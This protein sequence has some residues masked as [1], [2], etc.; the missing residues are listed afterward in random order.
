MT[1]KIW[2]AGWDVVRAAASRGATLRGT[3]E[4]IGL[5]RTALRPFMRRGV[6]HHPEFDNRNCRDDQP[7]RQVDL[8]SHGIAVEAEDPRACRQPQAD[9]EI[10][11]FLGFDEARK[12]NGCEKVA[13]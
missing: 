2:G 9:S 6:A 7:H 5:C 10:E 8:H 13:N 1:C 4:Q 12:R 11:P 3:S